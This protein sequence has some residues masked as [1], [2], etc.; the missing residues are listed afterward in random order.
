MRCSSNKKY[1]L[2]DR[3]GLNFRLLPDNIQTVT[4]IFNSKTTCITDVNTTID[5][6]RLDFLDES[7]D[8]MNKIINIARDG[9]KLEGNEYTHGNLNRDV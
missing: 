4:T 8:E 7:I 1:Y 2:R 9:K 5:F 3:L 6:L